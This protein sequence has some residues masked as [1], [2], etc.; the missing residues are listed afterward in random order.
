[1]SI[2]S[3]MANAMSGLTASGRT[4]ELISNNI[5]NSLSENFGRR[6]LSLNSDVL[7]GYGSGVR[8]GKT[9]RAE[10][11]IATAS[12]RSMDSFA[13]YSNQKS[14]TLSR[15]SAAMGPPGNS[16][17]MA[18]V[19]QKFES[20][21][22]SLANNPSSTTHLDT[23]VGRA[24]D[25]TATLNAQSQTVMQ[26]RMDAD[27]QIA[28]NVTKLNDNLIEIDRLNTEMRKRFNSPLEVASLQDTQQRLVDEIADMVP[29]KLAKRNFGEI[30]IFTP[31]G[32]VLL[33]GAPRLFGFTP[34]PTI[35]Q[36][37]T[38]GNGALSGLT[39]NGVPVPIGTGGFFEGG[40]LSA[41]FETRDVIAPAHNSQLDALARD[42]IERFQNPAVDPTLLPG[43]AGLF[44]DTGMPFAVG[45]ETGLAGRIS[46]NSSA[47]PAQGG[48]SWRMRDG[49]NAIAQGDVGQNQ[50]IRNLETALMNSNAPGPNLGISTAQS[51]AG[52][53]AD[54]TSQRFSDL[55]FS[56]EKLAYARS[57]QAVLKS[58]ELAAT[59]VDSDEQLQR[60]LETE[61]AYAANARVISVVDGLL[62]QLLRI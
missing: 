34:T 53:A 48:A 33:D 19:F 8:I 26:I 32:G 45:N 46:V 14:D 10:N 37:M 4:A 30:A 21:I 59:G 62:E 9:T 57:Q 41:L 25:V 39:Q 24:N 52:F 54:L 11:V 23:S 13:N 43:D 16:G 1:M 17:S 18:T 60:L 44:T 22:V 36:A 61:K 40:Q 31:E 3:A 58:A 38:I 51:A 50:I 5:A 27:A 6:E 29:V 15:I 7:G 28:R 35:T 20:S 56:D 2:S 49:L 12:R 42:L 47:D 55:S